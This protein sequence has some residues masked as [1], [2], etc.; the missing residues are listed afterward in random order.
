MQ[1][2]IATGGFLKQAGLG[3][4]QRAGGGRHRHPVRVRRQKSAWAKKDR[5]PGL[6]GRQVEQ[7][8]QESWM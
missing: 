6:N 8:K 1:V 7:G 2:G 3:I 4:G 5:E